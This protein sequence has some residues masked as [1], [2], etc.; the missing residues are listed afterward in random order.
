MH[1]YANVLNSVD[2]PLLT[3]CLCALKIVSESMSNAF[4]VKV[5]GV[6]RNVESVEQ[7]AHKI[8]TK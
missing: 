1:K 3:L 6:W 5:Y 7:L 4:T 8:D 2:V